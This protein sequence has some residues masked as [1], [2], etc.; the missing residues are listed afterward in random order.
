MKLVIRH[1]KLFIDYLLFILVIILVIWVYSNKSWP[2]S[3][4]FWVLLIAVCAAGVI[5]RFFI[6]KK[7][8]SKFSM[9]KRRNKKFEI[10]LIIFLLLLFSL[11]M[12][13]SPKGDT[14]IYILGF[15]VVTIS[16]L[17][18]IA[19]TRDIFLGTGFILKKK[20]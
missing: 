1:G 16:V 14:R 4:G 5:K 13:S 3:I 17:V 6:D 7:P 12:T 9:F 8:E 10:G 11:S 2:T 15:W 20:K 18:L 19:I